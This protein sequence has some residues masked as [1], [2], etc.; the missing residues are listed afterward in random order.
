MTDL[1]EHG[2]L[3]ETQGKKKESL[4]LFEEGS[5]NSRRIEGSC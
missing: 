5:G 4:P 2:T 3:A 1:A